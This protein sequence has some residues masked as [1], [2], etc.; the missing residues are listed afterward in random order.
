MK[1]LKMVIKNKNFY[2]IIILFL[3]IALFFSTFIFTLL[4][5]QYGWWNYYGWQL[6]EGT[7]LYKDLYCYLMPY[8]VWLQQVLYQVF[9]NKVLLYYALGIVIDTI[10]VSCIYRILCKLISPIWALLFAFTGAI[11]QYSYLMY[12][13]LDYNVFIADIIVI[14]CYITI[15]GLFKQKSGLFILSGFIF[16][17][18]FMMKQTL[19]VMIFIVGTVPF[20]VSKRMLPA[21]NIKK[22][23]FFYISG[24]VFA[25]MPG[26]IN[27]FI[28]GSFDAF[29]RNI[30]GSTGSKGSLS[31]ILYRMLFEGHSRTIMSL[32]FIIA[33]YA[34]WSYIENRRFFLL[35]RIKKQSFLADVFIYFVFLLFFNKVLAQSSAK[36]VFTINYIYWFFWLLFRKTNFLQKITSVV[37]NKKSLFSFIT[38]N[39][40]LIVF[41]VGT[42]FIL[43]V[44]YVGFDTRKF[45]Y[46]KSQMYATKRIIVELLYWLC[47][48]YSM[49]MAFWIYREKNVVKVRE[50][51]VFLLCYV[52]FV[53]LHF[54]STAWMEELYIMPLAAISMAIIYKSTKEQ[55]LNL[56]RGILIGV[57][58][59]III[60]AITQK[61]L[62]PYTWHGWTSTGLNNSKTV[63]TKSKIDD[64]MGFIFDVDTEEAYE[65]ILESIESYTSHEDK[66]FNFPHIPLFNIL[67]KRDTGMDV[68]AYYFDVCPD[69]LAKKG[70]VKLKNNPP[71]IVIWEEFRDDEW[72]L[73]EHVF[74]A[75]GRSGQRDILDWY[76]DVV[77]EKYDLVY[78]YKQLFV[79]VRDADNLTNFQVA[80]KQLRRKLKYYFM[81]LRNTDYVDLGTI[82]MDNYSDIIYSSNKYPVKS[83]LSAILTREACFSKWNHNQWE[84]FLKLSDVEPV[85]HVNDESVSSAKI[86]SLRYIKEPS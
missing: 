58:G 27:L 74:R 63:Y 76:N 26:I 81:D 48:F 82:N 51:F 29:V 34:V 42:S 56:V 30:M 5:P 31:T 55:H 36:T 43:L 12:F 20:I 83:C 59:F 9:G 61:Q 86:G 14:G 41:I 52:P 66:V 73:L 71:K 85:E 54:L 17:C 80:E 65:N 69:D 64:L 62:V 68:V 46:E 2:N 78:N 24:I 38:K 16:G 21:A 47:V 57:M 79:W 1:K 25:V 13:P 75:D 33:I 39:K 10:A 53:S 72:K 32:A 45:I 8:Y 18:T 23:V 15:I 4:P 77:K 50:E 28:N 35:E 67:T 6:S 7:V 37:K 49:L 22:Y 19:I 3:W 60:A 84:K 11:L 70:A 40:A 44:T